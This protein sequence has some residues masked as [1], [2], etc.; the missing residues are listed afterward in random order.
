MQSI[1]DL[2]LPGKPVW[3]LCCDHGYMGLNA[4]KSGSFTEVYFV[5]QVE[6]IIARLKERFEEEHYRAESPSQAYFLPLR[7][8]DVDRP[9]K[10]SVV[11][12]GVGAFTIF[13]IVQSLHTK[14][15]LQAHRLILCPQRDDQ[16]LKE[17]FHEEQNFGYTFCN[18]HG[19]VLERGRVRKLL[20]FDKN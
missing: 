1:Y 14:G 15:L 20:I 2:L 11:I 10:G 16:K 7:G 12:A 5:D 3:D 17:F 18:E 19:D 8:E 4:Y 13:K 6:H 9:L